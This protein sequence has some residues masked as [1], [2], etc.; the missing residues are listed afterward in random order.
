[1]TDYDAYLNG[2]AWKAKRGAAFGRWGR[3]CYLCGSVSRL[4]MHHVTYSR[5]GFESVNDLR[6]LCRRCHRKGAYSISAIERDRH[7]LFWEQVAIWITDRIATAAW[8][9]VNRL[10]SAILFVCRTV[11]NAGLRRE[12]RQRSR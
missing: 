3:R 2:V 5:F 4:E 7:A 6:P 9:V 10:L 12:S 1:M 8:A 11:S